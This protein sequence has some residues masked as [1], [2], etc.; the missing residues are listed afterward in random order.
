MA[1][2]KKDVASVKQPIR[3]GE[4]IISSVLDASITTEIIEF[5]DVASKV[6]FQASGDLAGNVEFSLDGENFKN[7]TA[8]GASNAIVS[9]NT[10]N[11]SA[12]KITRSG[13]SG[14][15]VFACK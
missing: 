10:H 6:S 4:K 15:V 8:I 14:S 9:F 13:G 1:Y 2:S 11:V 5:G 7:T 12:V 3:T